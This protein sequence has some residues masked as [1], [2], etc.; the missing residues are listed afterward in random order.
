MNIGR[1]G[2]LSIGWSLGEDR[3]R[4]SKG[5]D[6]DGS[7]LVRNCWLPRHEGR[8]VGAG[9]GVGKLL[10]SLVVLNDESMYY[11]LWGVV[12]PFVD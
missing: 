5:G 6:R 7:Y 11:L 3:S 10:G 8:G 12:D 2:E 4:D 9:F 1:D